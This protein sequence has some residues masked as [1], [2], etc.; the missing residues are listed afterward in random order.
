VSERNRFRYDS[1]QQAEEAQHIP[2]SKCLREPIKVRRAREAERQEIFRKR[3][4]ANKAGPP[5]A[6]QVEFAHTLGLS[7]PSGITKGEISQ[8]IQG[9]VNRRRGFGN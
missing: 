9:E 3:G 8:L 2:C 1:W 6:A 7:I 4:A 5:T